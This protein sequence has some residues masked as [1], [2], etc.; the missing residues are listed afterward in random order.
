MD[1]QNSVTTASRRQRRLSAHEAEELR[2]LLRTPHFSSTANWKPRPATVANVSLLRSNR[3][4]GGK[5]LKFSGCHGPL[6]I[7]GH[8]RLHD[9][10]SKTVGDPHCSVHVRSLDSV[11]PS[12]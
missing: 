1:Q 8:V 4:V 11:S 7:A 6:F 9:P 5:G 3:F 12:F 10:V 2:A